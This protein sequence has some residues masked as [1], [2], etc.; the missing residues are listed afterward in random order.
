MPPLP[1]C[2]QPLPSPEGAGGLYLAFDKPAGRPCHGP[3]SFLSDIRSVH[4]GDFTLAHR[5]D[6]DTSGVLLLARG[7][8]AL[9][10]AHAAWGAHVSK[11]YLALVRGGPESP[12]GTI[13]APLLENRTERPVRLA[14]G[15]KAAF[16]P[17]RAGLLLAGRQVPGIPALPAPGR[18]SVHPGGRP[19]VTVWRLAGKRGGNS[20]LE[21]TPRQGRMHQIRVHLLHA[22][23]P[24][25]GDRLYDPGRSPFDPPP[26][27]RSIR[28]EWD[29]PPGRPPGTS[30]AWEVPGSPPGEGWEMMP[31]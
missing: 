24:I 10:D 17:A 29:D 30:W 25:L 13:D 4:G 9:R 16:G 21:L 12:E 8:D 7:P 15:L 20:L 27:L 11:T 28:L 23:W 6:R 22:G 19:A 31:P 2:L 26:F 5:L 1:A 3:G 14:R 18:T